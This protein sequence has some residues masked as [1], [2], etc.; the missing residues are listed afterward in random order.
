MLLTTPVLVGSEGSSPLPDR[1]GGVLSTEDSTSS[2]PGEPAG[3]AGSISTSSDPGE[4]AGSA[5]SIST[6]SPVSPTTS[7]YLAFLSGDAVRDTAR[8]FEL[9]CGHTGEGPG[10]VVLALGRQ[11]PGGAQAF[12]P[13]GVVRPYALLGDVVAAYAE[14][15]AECSGPG[16]TVAVKTSNYKATDA[17]VH[18]GYGQDWARFA[19]GLQAR[20]AASTGGA[21]TVLAGLDLEPGWSSVA[22]AQAWM[23]GYRDAGGGPLVLLPSADGCPPQQPGVCLNGWSTAIIGD[24]VWGSG[25]T[26]IILPQVYSHTGTMARQWATIAR[27]AAARG[28]EP[29]LAGVTSQARA[30]AQI[31]DDRLCSQLNITWDVAL[32]Q[33]QSE[34]AS[35]P[36]TAHLVLRLATDIG[37][38]F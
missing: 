17:A 25:I 27:D 24:M 12:G 10:L 29:S 7:R 37:W 38:E 20:V 11:R 21:V 13:R 19:T 23:D 2:D 18:A 3:S 8:A 6:S 22:V 26:T 9:G 15:L 4:P 33:L 5:G 16:W 34:L 30:C 32:A 31:P 28:L 14:A 35:D 1:P 36:S